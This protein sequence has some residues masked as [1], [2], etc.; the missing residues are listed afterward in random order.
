[1]CLEG[2]PQQPTSSKHTIN[3]IFCV[4]QNIFWWESRN[5][6]TNNAISLLLFVPNSIQNQLNIEVVMAKLSFTYPK[7]VQHYQ[8]HCL[9][10]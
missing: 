7:I 4:T 10:K 5:N 2:W 8:K 6:K 1:M 3:P 9:G